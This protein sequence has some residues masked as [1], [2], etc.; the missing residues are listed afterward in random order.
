[1]N[2][3]S[4]GLGLLVVMSMVLGACAPSSAPAN[5]ASDESQPVARQA[6]KSL[7][8]GITST[9]QAFAMAG[10]T[11]TAGGW[12]SA[13]EIHSQGL[14]TSDATNRAP[15]GRLAERVPSLDDGTISLQPDGRMRVVYRLR[16]G[17]TWQDGAPFSADDLLFS[18]QLNADA[19]L[20]FV[21]RDA[22]GRMESVEASDDRT[23]V[24]NFKS[25]YYLADSLGLRLFWV[26]PR[27]L[28][29]E[30]YDRYTAS[31]NT[32][33]FLN[34]P[35]FTAGYVNLGPFRVTGFDPGDGV[36]LEAYPGYFLGRPKLD[37]IRIRTFGNENA[38]FAN[39]LGGAVDM[40][41]DLALSAENGLQLQE[42]WKDTNEG[43]VYLATGYI[44]FLVP[45]FRSDFQKEPANLDPR[46]RR[47]L[48][49]ALDREALSTALQG[50]HSEL[51][52]YS[53][54]PPEDRNYEATRDGLKPINYDPERARSLL[55]DVGWVAGSDAVLR[56]ATDGRRFQTALWATPGA[57]QEIAAIA[58]YWR[59]VGVDAE[60]I[61]IPP[62]FTRDN[63]YRAATRAGRRRRTTRTP[64]SAA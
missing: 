22:V 20:P 31:K 21:N 36:T 14:V 40:Y 2:D 5:R 43:A 10:T 11:T 52:A 38:L 29:Q 47:A 8:V 64:F 48:Y 56:N 9:V 54:L 39:L 15:V 16:S 32:D 55:R 12:M 51:A 17:V 1:M 49:H 45:Q 34:Q 7:T 35:Y 58:D 41:M 24:I 50:G 25:S 33:E 28:L 19:G 53:M 61:S 59:R 26:Y 37:V 62:A 3:K 18:Y 57:E 42:R 13:G 60:E 6:P 27:H 4:V 23:F 63:Q 44:R 30:P 46:V